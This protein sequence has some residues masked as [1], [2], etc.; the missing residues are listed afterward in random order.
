LISFFNYREFIDKYYA[1]IKS[2]NPDLP[3]LVR[4][5]SNISPKIWARYEY[6]KESYADVSN[7]SSED[8]FK[9]LIKLDSPE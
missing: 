4:E 9:T 3:I 7:L 5:C 2:S 1:Q 6:G 8:I